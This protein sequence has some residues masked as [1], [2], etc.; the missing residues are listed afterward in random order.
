MLG[1]PILIVVYLITDYSSY[2]KKSSYYSNV[3][4]VHFT[5]RQYFKILADIGYN[6][7]RTS[8]GNYI[9]VIE[10][11]ALEAISQEKAL[12]SYDDLV[13]LKRISNAF[14]TNLYQKQTDDLINTMPGS[15]ETIQVKPGTKEWQINFGTYNQTVIVRMDDDLRDLGGMYNSFYLDQPV[16]FLNLLKEIKIQDGSFYVQPDFKNVRVLEE[17]EQTGLKQVKITEEL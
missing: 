8:Q 6:L 10:G 7:S 11:I 3:Y 12:S 1:F 17:M 14:E 16:R 9:P 13:R 5:K 2:S 15:K 4:S